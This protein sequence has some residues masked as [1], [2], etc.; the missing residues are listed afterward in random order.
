MSSSDRLARRVDT[1]KAVHAPDP[2]TAVWEI[3]VEEGARRRLVGRTDVPDAIVDLREAAAGSD[4]AFEVDLLPDPAV[5]EAIRAIA[6]RSLAHLRAE[7]RHA[8]ELVHQMLL[9]EEALVLQERDEWLQVRTADPYVAWVHRGSLVRRIPRDPGAFRERLATRK[10]DDDAWVV[11]ARSAIARAGPERDAEVAADLVEGGIVHLG[12]AEGDALRIEL[13][14][15]LVG[16]VPIDAVVPVR[17]LTRHFPRDGGAALD[18]A[19]AFLGLPYL[20]GGASEKGFDCSGFVQR[21][22][23]LHGIDLPRDSDQ[24][25]RLGRSVDPELAGPG[26]AAGDL[27]FFSERADGRITHV[28]I[29]DGTGRMLHASTTRNGVAWDSLREDQRS[30]FGDRL[31][32]WFTGIRRPWPRPVRSS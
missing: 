18:H 8:A 6:H 5:G 26:V 15:G 25:A 22:F 19:A 31:A 20:W 14:D 23:S 27:A 16:W 21:I 1:L 29:L 30:P 9:G 11:V 10:R 17:D 28:G 2:R 3:G 13:P 4:A 7:P 12:G 24:Q 32:A